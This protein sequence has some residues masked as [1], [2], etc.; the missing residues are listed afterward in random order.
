[1][2]TIRPTTSIPSVPSSTSTAQFATVQGVSPVLNRIAVGQIIEATIISQTAPNTFQVR[3]ALGKF[4]LQST[5]I[6]PKGGTLIL[7]LSSQTPFMQFQVNS[8]N[9]KNPLLKTKEEDLVKTNTSQKK[10][11]PST[12]L[13]VGKVLLATMVDHHSDPKQKFS[14]VS[15]GTSYPSASNN[16]ISSEDKSTTIAKV[17]SF[18]DKSVKS[19]IINEPK[20]SNVINDL[21]KLHVLGSQKNTTASTL[22]TQHN[23]LIGNKLNVK[24][25]AIQ[26][27]DPT[28]ADDTQTFLNNKKTISALSIGTNLKGTISGTTS[29]GQPIVQTKAGIF[30]LDTK[31]MIPLGS[32]I[33]LEVTS[34]PSS[35]INE[36]QD[37]LPV[38]EDFYRTQNWSALEQALQALEEI[39]P[40][41]TH[42][43]LNSIIPRPGTALISNIIF[44][45]SAI[46]TGDLQ[47]WIGEKTLRVIERH[48]PNIAQKI[49]EDFTVLSKKIEESQPGDWRIAVVPV[50]SG[51]EIQKIR[52]LLR[53][54]EED[55]NKE[56]T[57]HS[58][59][60]ID[61]QLSRIGR[62]QLDGLVRDEG[63]SFE[64]I[65]R[66]DTHLADI[67]KNKIR[68]IF[69][70]TTKLT[71]VNGGINFQAAPANFVDIPEN[72][73]NK[74]IGLIV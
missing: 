23:L 73:D 15:K 14:Q 37:S 62:L 10:W 48:Q 6:L 66:T 43:F 20:I 52:L 28:G 35:S 2:N 18:E 54:N 32:I 13:A 24:V 4:L 9:G 70:E 74:N 1:M 39:H 58:R 69:S 46:K 3:T 11:S 72:K 64:L 67:I 31:T 34:A 30:T 16:M 63:N 40:R 57:N 55:T 44:F 56:G 50:N 47:S 61:I 33:S 5:L 22:K 21:K 60:I 17:R 19:S 53:Q 7:Q 12:K 36:T 42:K 68:T 38:Y 59:F 51:D 41:S 8:V 45:L 71:G 29:T 26:Q 27:P 25:I 49:K 65:I